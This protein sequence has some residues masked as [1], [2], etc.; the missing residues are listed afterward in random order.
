MKHNW[1]Y[2]PIEDCFAYIK[3]GAT[4]KQEKG[5]VGLP[6]TRI[7]TLSNGVFNRS[8]MGYANI[9]ELGK[10]ALNVLNDGD[11]LM[12]HI[13]SKTYVGRTVLYEA[14]PN[15]VIIHG[16][17]LLR[18][19]PNATT[20][21]K[22]F[23]YITLSHYFKSKIVN[24]RK[25][26]VN[27]SSFSITDLKRI[28]I[29]VPPMEVQQQIIAELDKINGVIEDCRELQRNLDVLAQSLFY[30]YFGDPIANPKNWKVIKLDSL[31]HPKKNILRASKKFTQ[32]DLITYID[33]SSINRNSN[34]I[35]APS[36]LVFGDAPSRAQQCVKQGDLL[37]S[38][39]RPNL[40]NIALCRL[41]SNSLVASSGFCVLRSNN[42]S[43]SNFLLHLL[44]SA[45]TTEYLCSK[46]SGAAYP[47]ITE[48]DI[49]DMLVPVPPLELQEKFAERIEQINAQKTAVEETIANLQT[50]L[51]SR[52]DYWFN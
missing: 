42:I 19:I 20:L 17:N 16:M 41:T 7:E 3:N 35:S 2:K 9:L 4:I 31:I 12:S 36:V 30:D 8:K 50:L 27:Q 18:L 48:N 39:V 33:I 46:I 29:P 52:M 24:I 47:A 1:E 21:S 13:N 37:V 15:E 28:P 14:L 38:L 44:L 40:K 45:S 43:N 51:N 22:F 25:D 23:Y 34:S 10:Y 49:R 32:N 11:L 6:I 5:A 26:A